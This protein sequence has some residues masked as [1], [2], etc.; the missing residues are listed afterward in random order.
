M[1]EV[2][3]KWSWFQMLISGIN[4]G[5]TRTQVGDEVS[6]S[7]CQYG[8]HLHPYIPFIA[9]KFSSN[10][11]SKFNSVAQILWY[12]LGFTIKVVENKLP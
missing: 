6:L 4:C 5:N 1:R 3:M 8:L 11:V 10:T 7:C 9:M 12:T 2:M